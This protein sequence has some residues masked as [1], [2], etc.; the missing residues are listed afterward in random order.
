MYELFMGQL[1]KVEIFESSNQP[2]G[3]ATIKSTVA[4]VTGYDVDETLFFETIPQKN[5]SENT[6]GEL[7]YINNELV[8]VYV[9]KPKDLT[10]QVAKL[11]EEDLNNKEAIAELYLLSMGGF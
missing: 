11:K 5:E 2:N 7:H 1:Q 9:D 8:W 3:Q 6:I 10:E 4:T